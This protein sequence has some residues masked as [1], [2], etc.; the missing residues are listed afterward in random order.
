[1]AGSSEQ[2]SFDIVAPAPPDAGREYQSIT[3]ELVSGVGKPD[4]SSTPDI[5]TFSAADVGGR[6]SSDRFKT[7]D[8]AVTTAP[9]LV[10]QSSETDLE[11][12]KRKSSHGEDS[13]PE[14][15]QM[16][17]KA[18]TEETLAGALL[19]QSASP[20]SPRNH[21]SLLPAEIW[22]HIFTFA[23]PTELGSLLLTS[24]A[25]H[26][27]LNPSSPVDE[28]TTHPSVTSKGHLST[29]KPDVIWQT[30][31]RRFLPRMP[32]PLKN[33]TELQMWRLACCMRCQFCG[34]RE[35]PCP[36]GSNH[37]TC[38]GPGTHGVSIVWPFAV[39]SCGSCLLDRSLKEIDLL[40][41]SVPS[42]IIPA[43]PSVLLTEDTTILS[44][45]ALQNGQGQSD[46]KLT[47]L[48]YA[49]HIEELQEEFVAVKAMG[50]ATAEEWLKGLEDRGKEL[51]GDLSRWEKWELAGGI[52]QMRKMQCRAQ[53]EPPQNSRH[54]MVPSA[55]SSNVSHD[56][57]AQSSTG[58]TIPVYTTP[59]ADAQQKSATPHLGHSETQEEIQEMKAARRMEI[60]RRAAL[61]DP[62]LLPSVLAHIPSFQA[63]LQIIQPLDNNAWDLL[64]TR[65]LAQRE[66]AEWRDSQHQKHAA[67]P[68]DAR[69]VVEDRC[70]VNGAH[71]ESKELVDKDWDDA[72][73]PLRAKISVFA[74]ET[75]KDAWHDG[76]N[77]KKD[78]CP[79]FAADVLLYVRNRFYAEVT[80][81]VAAAHAAGRKPTRDP[82]DGPFTQ[83]LTLENMKW[84][85]EVKIKPLTESYRKELFLCN[86]CDGNSKAYG[87]EGVIQHYAAKHTSSLSLGNIVVYWRSEWP[88]TP[89]FHP[90]P[91]SKSTHPAASTPTSNPGIYQQQ[92]LAHAPFNNLP[93]AHPPPLQGAL[94]YGAPPYRPDYGIPQRPHYP[95]YPASQPPFPTPSSYIPSCHTSF[96]QPVMPQLYV[97]P[98]LAPFYQQQQY[99]SGPYEH[100]IAAYQRSQ[101][102]YGLYSNDKIRVQLE[103]LAFNSRD[104]WMALASLKDLPGNVRVSV[105]IFHL[106]KRYRT[107]FSESPPLAMFID[108]LSNKKDMR[109]VRNVNGLKCKAC[110]LRLDNGA[111]VEMRTFSLPQLANHFQQSHVGPFQSS[112]APF[113]DWTVDM[114]YV[115]DLSGIQNMSGMDVREEAL[116]AEAFPHFTTSLSDRQPQETHQMGSQWIRA[117][118]YEAVISHPASSGL[119]LNPLPEPDFRPSI[120]PREELHGRSRDRTS[121]VR[122]KRKGHN[123][124]S[125]KRKGNAKPNDMAGK[126]E[127]G[128]HD[129]R[130]GDAEA[131]ESRQEEAI[132][133]IWAAER[134]ETAR[135][136]SES[137]ARM[138]KKRNSPRSEGTSQM[139]KRIKKECSSPV[140]RH[141]ADHK[142]PWLTTRTTEIDL[143]VDL[144]AGL[145]SHLNQQACSDSDVARRV[146]TDNRQ[147]TYEPHHARVNQPLALARPSNP[148]TYSRLA[149]YEPRPSPSSGRDG[150]RFQVLHHRVYSAQP[151]RQSTFS[152][153]PALTQSHNEGRIVGPVAAVYDTAMEYVR[154]NGPSRDR[155]IGERGD[156]VL[157][158]ASIGG[159]AENP[160]VRREQARIQ[161]VETY[162][163]VRMRDAEGEYFIRRPAGREMDAAYADPRRLEYREMGSS[164]DYGHENTAPS[165]PHELPPPG[166][167]HI[168]RRPLRDG[169]H[170]SGSLH[171]GEYDPR[172]GSALPNPETPVRYR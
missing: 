141:T 138:E 158:D 167:E 88:A 100:N 10:H 42:L 102:E 109:P 121:I 163:L 142:S 30:S 130:D 41:S 105:V 132:R 48:F 7:N 64:K 113:L 160:G 33:H 145:E 165:S 50:L 164:T 133:A 92:Y 78:N 24:R 110:H 17:K 129:E 85:F 107:R 123:H 152:T 155:L 151:H 127:N 40:L 57:R 71:R 96:E 159:Y 168:L 106:T 43:L 15:E 119:S 156:Q 83:K 95:Q 87:F 99:L 104:V 5:P 9:I 149:S 93:Q 53:V 120:A 18:K 82:A 56:G 26:S 21:R 62:P 13:M 108:G 63:A 154:H 124:S 147:T 29:L 3:K 171:Y 4:N 144:F 75:I 55:A 135:L 146:P 94:G 148:A 117:G 77:V 69:V 14:T 140:S 59:P 80:K 47:K 136:V 25:F 139:V 126:V 70:D 67:H 19:Q 97:P 103:D 32:A 76:N 68:K 137:D 86:G 6:S 46:L 91:L 31:R 20:S 90:N 170:E 150:D 38:S 51:R 111:E 81:D 52:A 134:R 125:S 157:R 61:L 98:P 161:Y 1:M 39:S 169:I 37:K 60:E 66:D 49:R 112:G 143:G 89:P 84:L 116:V 8:T 74:D 101:A 45:A 65:L 73:A 12:R 36:V 23:S 2:S 166:S 128:I 34:K 162:E 72:Q 44:P 79:Q 131:E 54:D 114:I 27:Y 22:Q 58:Q 153:L 35:P 11:T 16:G 172:Y 28:H 115:P 122:E 118:E